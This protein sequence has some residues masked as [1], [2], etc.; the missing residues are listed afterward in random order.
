LFQPITDAEELNR[1]IAERPALAVWFSGPDC[2]V[3]SSLKPKLEQLFAD[4]F[5]SFILSEINCAALPECAAAYLV[6]SVPTLII[7][8]QG[9]ES[10]RT[11]RNISLS[12]LSTRLE[13]SYALLF[14]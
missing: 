4:R 14:E 12:E 10:L 2:G 7:F 13:R 6:F 3:C 5:P 11:G 9:R 1:Q 8:L